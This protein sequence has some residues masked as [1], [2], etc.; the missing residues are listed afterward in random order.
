M[1][2]IGEDILRYKE[3]VAMAEKRKLK[4]EGAIGQIR[5]RLSDDWGLKNDQDVE[6]YLEELDDKIEQ[7]KK[8]LSQ[9]MVEIEETYEC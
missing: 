8:K 3:R 9:V 5:K 6:N 4:V 7:A 2:K 1:S